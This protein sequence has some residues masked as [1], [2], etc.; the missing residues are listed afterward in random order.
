MGNQSETDFEPVPDFQTDNADLIIMSL[1]NRAAYTDKIH[2]CLY[3][4]NGTSESCLGARNTY[5][6]VCSF[7]RW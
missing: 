2:D 3:Q 4:F 6:I 1:F 7:R 5:G